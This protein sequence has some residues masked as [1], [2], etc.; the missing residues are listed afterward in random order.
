MAWKYE[1]AW[2]NLFMALSDMAT[3]VGTIQDRLADAAYS[4]ITKLLPLH[5]PDGLQGDLVALKAMLSGTESEGFSSPIHGRTA[6][7]TDER[8]VEVAK[9]IASLFNAVD[10][11]S[12]H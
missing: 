2:R 10:L 7:M 8:A 9:A 3:S 1:Y 12:R 4:H 6:M 11:E 5:F